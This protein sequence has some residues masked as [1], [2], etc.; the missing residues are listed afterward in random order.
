MEKSQ[1]DPTLYSRYHKIC[2]PGQY[3]SIFKKL[4]NGRAKLLKQLE[5]LDCDTTQLRNLDIRFLQA[6]SAELLRNSY[7][8]KYIGIKDNQ[9]G[10]LSKRVR[11][12]NFTPDLL[13]KV[14]DTKVITGFFYPK[15]LRTVSSA[16]EKLLTPDNLESEI[17][18]FFPSHHRKPLT[19][20]VKVRGSWSNL[21]CIGKEQCHLREK[22]NEL[23][24]KKSEVE[25]HSY[26]RTLMN[27][28]VLTNSSRFRI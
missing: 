22:E 12:E 20:N 6:K 11:P 19:H 10:I 14:E 23:S 25:T 5:Q 15:P 2:P 21:K 17:K 16:S 4:S 28:G 9:I 24:D 1:D 3:F 13:P 18:R 26:S 7:S 27:R 8:F